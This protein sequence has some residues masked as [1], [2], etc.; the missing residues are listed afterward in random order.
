MGQASLNIYEPVLSLY[1][2]LVGAYIMHEPLGT[3]TKQLSAV[4]ADV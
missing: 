4:P 2:V 1:V 3:M